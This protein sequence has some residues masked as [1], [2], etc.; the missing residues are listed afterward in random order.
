VYKDSFEDLWE[1]ATQL[2]GECGLPTVNVT[3]EHSEHGDH[4]ARVHFHVFLGIE[5]KGGVGFTTQPQVVHIRNSRFIWNRISPNVKPT[6]T[7]R[8]SWGTIFTAVATGSYYVAGP[9]FGSILKRG[10]SEP[11]ED[12]TI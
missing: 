12:L 10:T 1:F 2:S 3:M 8:K 5:L 9:K 4:P 11:I 6:I 7:Q